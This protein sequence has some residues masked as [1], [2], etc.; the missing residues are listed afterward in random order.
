MLN[1]KEMYNIDKIDEANR[2]ADSL[3]KYGFSI[4]EIAQLI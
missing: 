1:R 2:I 3:T 4:W